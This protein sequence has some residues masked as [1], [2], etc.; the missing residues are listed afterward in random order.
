MVFLVGLVVALAFYNN[1]LNL[2]GPP[3]ALYVPVNLIAAGLLL[4]AARTQ[5]YPWADLGVRRAAVAPGLRWGGAVAVGV[6]VVL[7]VALFVPAADPLLGDQRVAGLTAT[8]LAYQVLVRIPLG[9]VVLEEVAFRGVLLGVWA[10]QRS[11]TE[12]V[13]GSS[14]V[15]G[16]LHI[17]PTQVLL[18]VNEV[19]LGLE[20]TVL[21]VGAA[22]VTTAVAG[23]LF[24]L[25]RLRT[26]GIVAPAVAH[27]AI[28]GLATVAAFVAQRG[29]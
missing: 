28:N 22:V 14:V 3:G 21:A 10:R 27:A 6:A 15:F 9:T 29:G 24:C 13:V 16:L 25:L 11:W 8:G 4:W 26:G 20:G 12:A 2:L 17:G 19:A 18:E 23:V 1:A 5:G 7:G